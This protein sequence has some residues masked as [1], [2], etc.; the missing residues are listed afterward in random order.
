MEHF[1]FQNRIE[2]N[3]YNNDKLQKLLNEVSD[4]YLNAPTRQERRLILGTVTHVVTYPELLR[5]IPELNE[6]EFTQSRKELNRIKRGE[7]REEKK[8]IRI[9]RDP[10]SINRFIE[11]ITQ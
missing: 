9:R 4:A 5:F 2:D 10:E 6:Y 11:F 3:T 8:I 7:E 1:S